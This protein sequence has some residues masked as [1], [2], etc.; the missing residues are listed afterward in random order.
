M[1]MKL[2]FA[3]FLFG[4]VV[5]MGKPAQNDEGISTLNILDFLSLDFVFSAVNHG[6]KKTPSYKLCFN[7]HSIKNK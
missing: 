3:L 5:V 2:A 7:A 6:S 4:A 1:T